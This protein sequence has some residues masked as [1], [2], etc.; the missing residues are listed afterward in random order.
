MKVLIQMISS[1]HIVKVLLFIS[2]PQY[3]HGDRI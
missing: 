1:K 2:R 3:Q